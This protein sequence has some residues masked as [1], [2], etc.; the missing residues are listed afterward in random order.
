M[1]ISVD[2]S[3]KPLALG[4]QTGFKEYTYVGHF[5]TEPA[6]NQRSKAMQLGRTND[7][8]QP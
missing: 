6:A 3:I 1:H 8:L 7:L 2:I 5:E 4:G